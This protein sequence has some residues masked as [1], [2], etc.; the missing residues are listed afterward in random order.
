MTSRFDRD[1]AAVPAG[2]GVYD[3]RIDEGWWIDRGPNGG[4]LAGCVTQA[5]LA[6]VNSN[7]YLLRSITVHYLAPPV[8][9]PAQVHV[10]TERAGRLARF[11]SARLVQGDKVIAMAQSVFARTNTQSPAFADPSFPGYPQPGEMAHVPDPPG[12]S[13]MRNRYEYLHVMGAP[14]EEPGDAALSGGWIRLREPR[15]YDAAIITAMCDA[16][17]PPVFSRLRDPMGVPTLDLTVH[18][19][20]VAAMQRLRPDD[21]VAV[22]FRT[23]ISAEG[24]VEEDG[25]I[26]APDGT[27][28]AHSRQLAIL[29]AF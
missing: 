3:S 23:S 2:N 12:M 18:V 26:W 29:L 11:L 13:E 17:H 15:P 6:E 8:A 7:E 10:T 5:L 28:I 9:G 4:Y 20:S 25:H 21:W 1:T 19:R 24:F 22:R 27:L 16:W 14:W